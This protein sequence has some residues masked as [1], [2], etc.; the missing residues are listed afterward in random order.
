VADT[1][2]RQRIFREVDTA[3]TC[4]VYQGGAVPDPTPARPFAVVRFGNRMSTIPTACRLSIMVWVHDD[5]GSYLF[6]DAALKA[7]RTA[8]RE[9]GNDNNIYQ[10]RWLED[11]EDLSDDARGTIVKYSRYELIHTEH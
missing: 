7:L 11:S 1:D 9:Q 3:L 5:P 8:F 10:T 4:P 2:P 6:I